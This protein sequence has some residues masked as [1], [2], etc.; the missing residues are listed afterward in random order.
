MTWKAP[1]GDASV[2]AYW[3]FYSGDT[4]DKPAELAVLNHLAQGASGTQTVVDTT[5]SGNPY[6]RADFN[7]T[8]GD[9]RWFAGAA[10][11]LDADAYGQFIGFKIGVDTA[12]AAV[13]YV[14]A[15]KNTPSTYLRI[16][17]G[18]DKKLY[19]YADNTLLITSTTLVPTTGNIECE[20][21]CW[22]PTLGGIGTSAVKYL[23]LYVGGVEEAFVSTTLKCDVKAGLWF[24]NV[25][26][27]RAFSMYLRDACVLKSTDSSDA[28]WSTQAPRPFV[29]TQ[30][31][32]GDDAAY[33]DWRT[34]TEATGTY[35]KWDETTGHDGDTTYNHSGT[36]IEKGQISTGESRATVGM[37]TDDVILAGPLWRVTG[38]AVTGVGKQA[39]IRSLLKLSGNNA[40]PAAPGGY[41]NAY[42]G[43][44]SMLGHPT[45]G[46]WVPSD[47]DNVSFGASTGDPHDID[48][49]ISLCVLSWLVRTASGVLPLATPPPAG[50]RRGGVMG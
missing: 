44:D 5:R 8:A 23:W 17:I 7:A 14:L 36:A 11:D 46:T 48:V 10:I 21:I 15:H 50:R 30:F 13:T 4:G 32:A 43:H 38:K 22:C 33:D 18:T 41:D 42:G 31:P 34:E 24:E 6:I 12:P 1:G 37:N 40:P 25:S 35:T 45:A 49:R 19:I 39:F 26:T 16:D 2:G 27:N 47:L 29:L 3:P 20:L 9:R 28:P